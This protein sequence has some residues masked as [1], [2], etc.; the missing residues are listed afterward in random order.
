MNIKGNDIR[1][2]L[3]YRFQSGESVLRGRNANP[4]S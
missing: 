1:L 4:S 2:A 3:L